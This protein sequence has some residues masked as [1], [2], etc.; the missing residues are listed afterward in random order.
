MV[1]GHVGDHRDVVAGQPD[2]LEQDAAAR[3]LGDRELAPAGGPA[4][5][6]LPTGPS[7]PPPPPARR[8]CRCRRCSTS[9]PAG[10]PPAPMWA[11][12]REVVVLPLVPVTATT[13]TR[14]VIVVGAAP[15]SAAATRAAASLTTVSTSPPG[16]ASSTSA[17]AVAI[18][19]A[20][21]RCRHG[22]ATTIW[23]WSLVGRTRTASRVAPDSFG[24]RPDQPAHRAQRE[25]LP[26]PGVGLPGTGVAQPDPLREPPARS[27]RG[28]PPAPRC[29]GSA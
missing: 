3:G 5:A 1:G 23:C 15:G 21:V 11:I 14:G 16:T 4:P 18:T 13:G 17:T 26:E 20:R 25:P 24:D 27:P 8:R 7:S 29:R 6:P 22:K 12:I 19:C 9:R 10:R 2:A 28:R